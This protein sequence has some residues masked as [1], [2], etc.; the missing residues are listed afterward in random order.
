MMARRRF[1]HG[2][3][4][5]FSLGLAVFL[6]GCSFR[7]AFR[8]RTMV[9]VETPEGLKRGYAVR[10]VGFSARANGGDYGH[11]RGEAVVVDLGGGQTLFALLT[12]DG[13]NVDHAGDEM[14]SMFKQLDSDMIQ[15]WPDPPALRAPIIRHPLPMLVTFTDITDPKSVQRVDPANLAA[16]FGPGVKLKRI[17][18][19][20]TSERVT[21][22]IGERLAL[23]GVRRDH[24]LDNDFIMTTNPTLAQQ[25]GYKD[26]VK[27]TDQ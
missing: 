15:L 12:G 20:T 8:Y 23:I 10:E 18:V 25:I 5:V 6:G 21:T 22:G 27:G 3:L 13:G 2:V 11:V 16:S 17:V 19:E 24:S 14:A 26:F 9:E 7:P 1:A 4:G